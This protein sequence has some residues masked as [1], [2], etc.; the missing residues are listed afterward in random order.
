MLYAKL[1]GLAI[2]LVVI[3]ALLLSASML[4][5]PY[6][7]YEVFEVS[8]PKD[9]IDEVFTVPAGEHVCRER[10]L[11]DDTVVTVEFNA[12]SGGIDILVLNE[13]N[14]VRWQNGEPVSNPFPY[15]GGDGVASA[16]ILFWRPQ[17]EDIFFVWK[18]P[19]PLGPTEVSAIVSWTG[20]V[21]ENREVALYKPMSEYKPM[22]KQDFSYLGLFIL[23]VGIILVVFGVFRLYRNR[24]SKEG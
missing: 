17:G 6:T 24:K 9:W 8:G 22:L 19:N 5:V 18:N 14:Y 21:T 23:A 10:I 15:A 16:N 13:T 7:H 11:P 12:S 20:S 2:T 3:G 4:T 1:A